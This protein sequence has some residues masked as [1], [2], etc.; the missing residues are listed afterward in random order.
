M[1]TIQHRQTLRDAMGI[2]WFVVAV[3]IGAW[4]INALVFRSFSVTGPSME[5]TMYTGDRLIVNRLPMTWAALRGQSFMPSRGHVIVFRN[6]KFEEMKADE[7]VVKR[8]IALPG[9][10]VEV[11]GGKVIVYND[12]R[13]DGFD[14]YEG[15]KVYASPVTGHL[16]KT[17]VPDGS[18]FVIGDN[19]GGNESLDSRNGLGF[20]PL[21][22]IVGPVVIRIYPFG[23]ISTNF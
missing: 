11:T 15:V 17:A 18:I 12:E 14:P 21:D 4:L 9:E 20:I 19:R 2:V 10:H 23:K 13:P 3:I 16:D 1:L 7:F 5:S 8:V 6:P 22:N